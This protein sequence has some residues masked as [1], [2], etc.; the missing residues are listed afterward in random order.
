MIIFDNFF[1][2][3]SLFSTENNL[4]MAVMSDVY[5]T[6]HASGSVTISNLVPGDYQFTVVAISNNI[7]GVAP[8]KQSFTVGKGSN[9]LV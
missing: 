7:S 1:T 6:D 5:P 8:V 3:L 2:S 9:Q 4:V